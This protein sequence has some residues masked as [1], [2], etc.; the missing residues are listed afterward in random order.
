MY[1]I[2]WLSTI[3]GLT[4]SGKP[5]FQTEQDCRSECERLNHENNNEILHWPELIIGD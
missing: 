5:V 3:T 4:G 1:R 2:F